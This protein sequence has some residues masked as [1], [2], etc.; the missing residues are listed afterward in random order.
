MKNAALLLFF[1]SNCFFSHLFAQIENT[2]YF[3]GQIYFKFKDIYPLPSKFLS[4][5]ANISEF[6]FLNKLKDVYGISKLRASFYFAKQENLKRTF[7]LYFNQS[8][9]ID[10]LISQLKNDPNIEYAEKVP[11]HRKT[12]VP[13]DLGANNTGSSG[14]WFLHKIRAQQAWD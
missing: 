4:D 7:R 6:P 12:I 13:N 3:D 11:I 2:A 1:I 14:Q 9:K 8:D 10:E 5:K